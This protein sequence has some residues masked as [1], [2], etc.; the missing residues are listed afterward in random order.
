M[1]IYLAKIKKCV[2]NFLIGMREDLD[3]KTVLILILFQALLI[4]LKFTNFIDCSWFWV[5][6]PIL[7]Q[8]L[9]IIA[10]IIFLIVYALLIAV[11]IKIDYWLKN[12]EKKKRD[13]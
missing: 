13:L 8:L 9:V 3:M 2:F 1:F 10:V 7:S 4:W 12:T 6:F 11:N 5:L